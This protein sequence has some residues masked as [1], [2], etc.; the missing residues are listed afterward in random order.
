[1]LIEEHLGLLYY[2]VFF[3]LNIWT[4]LHGRN[5]TQDFHYFSLPSKNIFL[6]NTTIITIISQNN[7]LHQIIRAILSLHT[8]NFFHFGKENS[9]M[10]LTA[11]YYILPYIFRLA[12]DRC[13]SL[14]SCSGSPESGHN[15]EES[16]H[17]GSSVWFSLLFDKYKEQ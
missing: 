13:W 9:L 17:I 15:S 11:L 7:H 10:K 4:K 14:V 12:V 5:D 6:K 3:F 16:D 2:S 1:M 8:G